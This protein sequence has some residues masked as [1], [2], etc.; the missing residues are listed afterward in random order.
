[1]AVCAG[2]TGAK[3]S[4]AVQMAAADLS[5]RIRET[6]NVQGDRRPQSPE[7]G[8]GKPRLAT[9]AVSILLLIEGTL[10][11]GIFLNRM[12]PRTILT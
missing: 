4:T 2:K 5:E 6:I 8:G 11:S 10:P 12:P 9:T 7:S 3:A 1:L